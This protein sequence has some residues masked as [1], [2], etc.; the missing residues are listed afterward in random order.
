MRSETY[1][2]T[3]DSSLFGYAYHKIIKNNNGEICGYQ[4]LSANKKWLELFRIKEEDVIYQD[5]TTLIPQLKVYYEKWIENL[6]ENNRNI[7]EEYSEVNERW[8]QVEVV[9]DGEFFFIFIVDISHN[10]KNM[11][12]FENFFSVNLDLLCIAD[13]NGNFVKINNEWTNVLGYGLN[14]LEGKLFLD[15]VHPDDVK[16]TMEAVDRL[17]NNEKIINFVNRYRCK[18]GDYKYIEWRSHPGAKKNLIYAAAR[19]I[20]A[21]IVAEESLQKVLETQNIL[22]NNVNTQIWYLSSPY[23]YGAVN[24]SYAEF[25]GLRVEDMA[26]KNIY[27]IFKN[28]KEADAKVEENK[29]IFFQKQAKVY[30]VY[31]KNFKGE[32]KYLLVS[33][34]PKI[35]ERGN[36]EYVVCSAEDITERKEKKER[37]KEAQSIGNIGHWEYDINKKSFYWSKQTYKIYEQ[38]LK[39]FN[40]TIKKIFRLYPKEERK[41]II[42]QLKDLVTEKKET[43]LE[44]KII[45]PSGRTKYIIQKSKINYI[46]REPSLI[47]GTV[48][49]ITEL[50]KTELKLKSSE[51]NFRTFFETMEDMLIISDRKGKIFYSNPSALKKLG[52]SKNELKKLHIYDIHP[53]HMIGTA[54]KYF[55]FITNENRHNCQIPLETKDG[56]LIYAEAKIWIGQWNNNECVFSIIKDLS[57]EREA[58]DK[59]NKIFQENPALMVIS[60]FPEREYLDANTSFYQKMGY[61]NSEILCRKT[62]ELNF[63]VNKEHPIKIIEALVSKG[64]IKN[65]EVQLKTK[66]GETIT[67]LYSGVVIKTNSRNLFLSVLVDIT[68]QKKAERELI[69]AKEVAE[70]ASKAKS[71]FLA[72]MSHEIRTPMNAIIGLSKYILQDTMS[73]EQRDILNKIYNSSQMLLSIINDILDYSKIEAGKLKLD[74]HTFNMDDVLENIR[75]LFSDKI[76]EKKLDIYFDYDYSIMY[77]LEGDSLRLSQILINLIGN[78]I[79][80]TERGYVKLKISVEDIEGTQVVLKFEAIDTGIGLNP[81]NRAKLFEAFSQGD[82]STTRKFGGTGLGLVISSKLV[83]SMGGEIQVDSEEGKGSSFQFQIPLSIKSIEN[84]MLYGAFKNKGINTLIIN[85]RSKNKDILKDML[86]KFGLNVIEAENTKDALIKMK[87]YKENNNFF[88]YIF[89]DWDTHSDNPE[90][91]NEMKNKINAVRK[92][93]DFMQKESSIVLMVYNI[94]KETS[95]IFQIDTFLHKPLIATNVYDTLLRVKGEKE[96]CLSKEEKIFIPDLSGKKILLVEDNEI[97]QSISKYFLKKTNS[98]IDIVSNGLEAV[99]SAKEKKYDIILMDLQMPVM[100]GYEATYLIRQFYPEIP[101]VALSAAVTEDDKINTEKAGMNGHLSKPIEEKTLY[102]ELYK[103]IGGR[104]SI[105]DMDNSDEKENIIPEFLEGFDLQLGLK[106]SDYNENLYHRLLLSFKKQLNEDFLNISSMVK[107]KN[108]TSSRMIHTLKGLAG[109]VG[110]VNLEE[111]TNKINSIYKTNDIISNEILINFEHDLTIVKKSLE[112]IKE[113]EMVYSSDDDKQKESFK[114]LVEKLNNNELIEDYLIYDSVEYIKKI[115]PDIDIATLREYINSYEFDKALLLLK[116]I[117]N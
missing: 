112:E 21:R 18:N 41:K 90:Y 7:F 8:Y 70:K 45:T 28:R 46:N 91:T 59:F 116:Y 86:Q 115:S 67:G 27:D 83:K 39:S 17:K 61:G 30:E 62:T 6:P 22:L 48:L 85:D 77:S 24:K 101:I 72:N 23:E 1:K 10:K 88:H 2:N 63:F 74:I 66:F 92:S 103:W 71:E 108:E 89:F 32:H 75:I 60:S 4:L 64:K 53:E 87:K 78:A 37:L 50:K 68:K 113:K 106:R 107:E 12:E 25:H 110:A 57:K 3:L 104:N 55:E 69:L 79:K 82:T 114:I 33:I 44:T 47:I 54:K 49:D 19:D 65:M 73:E 93:L 16:K 95:E 29:K 105:E 40:P 51:N 14:E 5:I 96:K 102:E 117:I 43:S 56:H 35:E 100:D 94:K 15:F 20:T 109:M 36:I 42:K 26:F 99:D 76:E 34:L 58:L 98:D 111:T 97:N 31:T 38:N 13:T 9:L 52:Y 81:K 80:F 11:E 84:N